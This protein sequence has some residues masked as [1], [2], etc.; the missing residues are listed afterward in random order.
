MTTRVDPSAAGSRC[1]AGGN[2]AEVGRP[3]AEGRAVGR[4]DVAALEEIAL[5]FWKSAPKMLST[6]WL[7][8]FQSRNL[9]MPGSV[10]TLFWYAGVDAAACSDGERLFRV[11]GRVG[12]A[13]RRAAVDRGLIRRK[14]T[15]RVTQPLSVRVAT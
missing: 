6:L 8:S 14:P 4:P 1:T 13:L 7:P 10:R 2:R 5:W 9:L 3:A 12:R 15:Y 11:A